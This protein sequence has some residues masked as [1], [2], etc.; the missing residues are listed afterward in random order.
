MDKLFELFSK[1]EKNYKLYLISALFHIPFWFLSIILFNRGLIVNYPIYIALTIVICLTIIS[2]LIYYI[3]GELGI[4]AYK[5]RKE[6]NV[7]NG[8]ISFLSN[9]CVAIYIGY[10]FKSIH[11]FADFLILFM[12]F[13]LGN[14]IVAF[15]VK[16]Y[17]LKTRVKDLKEREKIRIKLTNELKGFSERWQKIVENNDVEEMNRISERIDEI[18]LLLKRYQ[19]KKTSIIYTDIEKDITELEQS[20]GLG[21]E[22]TIK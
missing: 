7:I 6:N 10:Y 15:L 4:K 19:L 2:S 13:T 12:G 22:P 11:N 16:Y 14:I 20:L 21:N 8:T 5:I 18:R 3:I 9:I 1:L 17:N